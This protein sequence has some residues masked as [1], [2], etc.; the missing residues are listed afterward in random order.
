MGTRLGPRFEGPIVYVT[1]TLP[2]PPTSGGH[3]RTAA[4]LAALAALA[5]T[6]L[7]AFPVVPRKATPPIELGS[8][9]VVPLAR[10]GPLARIGYRIAATARAGH[11]YL[12]RFR[13]RGGLA[14]LGRLLDEVRPAVVILE[15]PFYPSVVLALA[16]P[17][18]RFV[19][20]VADDRVL[21]AR[22]AARGAA[23]ASARIRALLDM[24]PLLAS[25]RA[26]DRLDQAWFAGAPDAE[27]ARRRFPGLDVRVIPNV[28][29]AEALAAVRRPPPMPFSAA[30]LGSFDYPPNEHAALRFARSI[31][32]R[33][34]RLE[35]T[36]ELALIGRAPTPAVRTAATSARLM[37]HADVADAAAVLARHQVMV[38]PL[39][40]G[41]GT[42]LKILEAL[43]AGIPVVSTSVGMAGLDLRPGQELLVAD[44]DDGLA[45][46]VIS[47]WRSP[48]LA[49]RLVRAGRHTALERYSLQALGLAVAE[50]LEALRGVRPGA[51]ATKL[52]AGRRVS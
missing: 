27:H 17:G 3:L 26:I 52:A 25:E 6:H 51:G 35:P 20:D 18:R 37:L 43:A 32:P 42:R 4:N 50:A 22:Q 13:R 12:E 31:A 39:A 30:F 7:V 19:A 24:P 48:D 34:R 9:T 49:G 16:A 5:P 14:A 40:M 29:D 47:V 11:P 21:L 46:A 33:L 38:V 41:S 28:V 10:P 44:D 36:A 23:S 45:E 1:A 2:W 8:F 15:Y